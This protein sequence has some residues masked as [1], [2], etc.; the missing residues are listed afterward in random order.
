MSNLARSAK[1]M[2][3]SRFYFGLNILVIIYT[4]FIIVYVT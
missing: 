3:V 1:E 4:L 2:Q